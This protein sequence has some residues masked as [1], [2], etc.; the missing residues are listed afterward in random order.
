MWWT[1]LHL[2][3]SLRTLTVLGVWAGKGKLWSNPA[4]CERWWY[5][6]GK[7]LITSLPII[8]LPKFS[9][10]QETPCLWETGNL[11]RNYVF[12]CLV[13]SKKSGPKPLEAFQFTAMVSGSSLQCLL[14][15]FYQ[16]L[17]SDV[18]TP[19]SIP[20]RLGFTRKMLPQHICFGD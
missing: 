6:T 20:L 18:V 11:L 5:H 14:Y 4:V 16:E 17:H 7:L 8:T 3:K 13:F 15:G 2:K 19:H 10:P 1:S 12:P 9:L